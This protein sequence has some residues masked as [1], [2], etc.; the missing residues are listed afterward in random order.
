MKVK[1][2]VVENG[3]LPSYKTKG[4]VGADCY[5]R[6][7]KPVTIPAMST[8][9]IPLGFCVEIPKGYEMQIRPR[10]GLATKRKYTSLGTIDSDYRGE[11]GAIF[12]NDTNEDFIVNPGD[13]IVQ[14]VIAPVIIAEW[15]ITKELSDT[16]RGNGGYGHTGI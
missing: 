13:R 16:D 9:I 8:K 12:Y 7:E 6:L 10:S 2:K 5:A 3:R 1:I 4:S 15:E 11:V 14:A